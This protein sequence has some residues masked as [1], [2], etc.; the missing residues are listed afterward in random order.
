[1][2]A[3]PENPGALTAE[4]SDA[5]LTAVGVTKRYG[6]TTALADID[7]A[8]GRGEIL[9]LVGHNGAGKSTLMRVLAGRERPDDGRVTWHAG[10]E[11]TQKS[12]A[13]AGVR[14]IYQELALCPDLTV[15]EN[16]ALS[17]RAARGWTW[18]RR[19][20]RDIADALDTVFPGHGI[21]IV[22]R[23]SDLSMAQRQMVEIARAL[24]TPRL[25][26]LILDEPTES[27][28]VDATR[29]LYTHLRRLTEQGISMVLISHRMQEVL[30]AADR[31]AVMKDGRVVEVV[32]TASTDEDA[33]LAAMG[34]EVRADTATFRRVTSDAGD[35]G[36]RSEGV[37]AR[38]AEAGSRPFVV[39][40]GEIVGLAGLAGH[41]QDALL[42]R[43]WANARGATVTKRRA[44]VPGD[45]QTSGIF[46]LWSVA[47]NLT[48][49]ATRRLSVAGVIRSA[50]KRRLAAEWVDRL[51]VKGGARAPITSLSGGNQQKVLV[52]RG[53][54]ADAA[55]VL[56][57]D[58]FRGVDVSTKNELYALM[59]VE[60]SRGRSIVW[61][62]TEN[63]EM[64]HCDRVYVFRSGRIVS[65]L[66]GD[67]ITEDRIIADSFGESRTEEP[68][69]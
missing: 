26:M 8:V 34:G 56:L 2:T 38:V 67:E 51:K 54:A 50:P 29:Q 27:L 37:V 18:R 41:G 45:R 33:L 16:I 17:D 22:R 42:R 5:V 25:S 61:Y 59:R 63:S 24:C 11:W 48:V 23:T 12:A 20:E 47:E 40:A 53:F 44:Y 65:E 55:L 6:S 68:V 31:I 30:A 66:S 7:L 69:R 3:A 32:A 35:K 1:M 39:G 58:P 21:S 13:D 62:S 10:G 9:G 15:A 64:A 52:A 14:M 43:L 60:A 49:S 57:D 4:V 46:P 28:S 19:A 36:A